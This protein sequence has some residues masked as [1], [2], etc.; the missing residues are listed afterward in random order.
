VRGTYDDFPETQEDWLRA[1]LSRILY[2][3]VVLALLI[4]LIC[5]FL[6]L[7]K[8]SQRQEH[9]LTML[10]SQIDEEKSINAAQSRK[11]KMLQND[12]DYLEVMARNKLDLMKPGETI[13]RMEPLPDGKK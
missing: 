13:F 1:L 3:L 11:L 6:P 8:D 7:I 2:I 5:W 10:Q 12:K 9:T 4:L